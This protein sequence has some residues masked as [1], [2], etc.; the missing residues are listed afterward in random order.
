[1]MEGEGKF[2]LCFYGFTFSI[3]SN[4]VEI[5]QKHTLTTA[6]TK[7]QSGSLFNFIPL[8]MRSHHNT[9]SHNELRLGKTRENQRDRNQGA[10]V[11]EALYEQRD[12]KIMCSY[13]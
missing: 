4:Q 8:V 11:G 9:T 7:L 13:S 1:M 2:T 6:S 3:I 5:L 10:K 12:A